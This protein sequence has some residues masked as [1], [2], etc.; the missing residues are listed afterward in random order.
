[1][2]VSWDAIYVGNGKVEFEETWG[3][4]SSGLAQAAVLEEMLYCYL[5]LEPHKIGDTIF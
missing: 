5:I 2:S 4:K 3:M 1:M